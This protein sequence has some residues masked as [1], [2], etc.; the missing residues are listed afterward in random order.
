[1]SSSRRPEIVLFGEEAEL[2][3]PFSILTGEFTVT[4]GADDEHC[5]VTRIST[6]HGRSRQQCSL[7]VQ[8]VL[9]TMAEQGALY[10]EVVELVRQ[11]DRCKCLTCT[12]AVDALPQAT[13]IYELAQG[14]R[15]GD[16][17]KTDQ[18]ILNAKAD[19]GA[20]PNLLA[21]PNVK[22][23]APAEASLRAREDKAS[24]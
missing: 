17:L 7:K 24:D 15:G 2:L 11:V 3:P 18:E 13:S 19:F 21:K 4:A 6:K 14:G 9:R 5:T 8:D 22:G 1:M 23:K 12:V 16:L 20:T 10:P